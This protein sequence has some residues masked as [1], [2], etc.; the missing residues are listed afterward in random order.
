MRN[1]ILNR[2]NFFFS[3]LSHLVRF[4]K[5]YTGT[6]RMLDWIEF[7]KSTN[8]CSKPDLDEVMKIFYDN[9]N[10]NSEVI[11]SRYQT[12]FQKIFYVLKI[13][14]NVVG[15]CVYYIHYQFFNHKISAIATIY[16]IAVEKSYR[17]RGYAD[18]LLTESILE[19]R[20]NGIRNVCL[21][22][23]I[24]NHQAIKLYLKHGFNVTNEVSNICG[25]GKKCYKMELGEN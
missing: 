6:L 13:D 12:L 11:I 14:K 10:S 7:K 20:N 15:Y 21:F 5:D 16:S 22:V 9:F 25:N 18:I 24:E 3:S 23:S 4:V 2:F 19:M 17:K 8:C 1:K